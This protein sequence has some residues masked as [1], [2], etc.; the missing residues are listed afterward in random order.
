M[1]GRFLDIA[2]VLITLGVEHYAPSPGRQQ[3]SS[4]SSEVI[5]NVSG[6][7]FCIDLKALDNFREC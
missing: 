2:N 7:R 4:P 5:K 1:A 3:C 6:V